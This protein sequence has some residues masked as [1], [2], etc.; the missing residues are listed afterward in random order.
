[1]HGGQ[2]EEPSG[3]PAA[4]RDGLVFGAHWGFLTF[5]AGLGG[6][7]LAGLLLTVLVSGRVDE[8]DPL[9]LPELGPVIL[10][11]FLPNVL[12]GLAP[13]A[14]SRIWGNG[15]RADFGI[16]PDLRD[17]KIGLACGGFAL[18]VGYLLNLVLLGVYGTERMEQ[19]PLTELAGGIGDN[20]GWLVLA[21]LVVVLAAPL[22][23]EIL[24]RGALWNGLER[25]RVPPWVILVLTALVFAYIH[26]EPART[27][28]L[29]GQGLV[30]GS[31]RL[32]TGRVGASLVAHAANNLP[33][34]LLLFASP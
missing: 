22:T 8:F 21:A 2:A 15:L 29:I 12:L 20:A 23:E 24:V 13:V 3:E 26:S 5:F 33:P 27:L 34:A 25:H 9:E 30:I 14:G 16:L 19:N 11:A 7:H 6:Y 18:L 10:L 17:L 31:A 32:I 28:A 1:M 4:A